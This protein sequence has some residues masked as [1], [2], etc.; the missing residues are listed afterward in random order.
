MAQPQSLDALAAWLG[1]GTIDNVL[2]T[3]YFCGTY[4]TFADKVLFD[5]ARLQLLWND[6]A[7][8]A[9]CFKCTVT[10]SRL[11][12]MVHFE[13]VFT[14]EEFQLQQECRIED[15][16]VRCVKCLREFTRGEKRDLTLNNQ[17]IFLVR[18]GVRSLCVV[19]QVGV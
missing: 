5:N 15:V 3:C 13:G 2:I 4:L 14:T 1:H 7:Y 11:E 10:T 12:F 18:G 19:C 16:T 17:D 8:Y 9:C 6:G